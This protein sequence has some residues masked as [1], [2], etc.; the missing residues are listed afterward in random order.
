M[1]NNDPIFTKIAS[2]LLSEYINICY[3]NAE[4]NEYQWYLNQSGSLTLQLQPR[5]NDFFKDLSDLTEKI[6]YEEDRQIFTKDLQK[7]SLLEHMQ[8]GTIRSIEYRLMIEGKPV[9]HALR[10]I[11]GIDSEDK[12]FILAVKNVDEEVRQRL[13]AQQRDRE[14]KIYNQ[15]AESLAKHYD[16]LYYVDMQDNEYFEYSSTDIYKS[17]QVPTS[18]S[19]FFKESEKNL[20]RFVHPEDRQRIV[21]F[22]E[23]ENMLECM[24]N[25]KSYTTEYRLLIGEDVMYCRTSMIWASDKRHILVGIVNINEEIKAQREL[26]ESKRQRTTYS[27][28]VDSL[29]S[30][31]DTIYYVN[32]NSGTVAKLCSCN[33]TDDP[34]AELEGLDFFKDS[35]KRVE[36]MVHENDRDRIKGLLD[37]DYIISTLENSKQYKADYRIVVDGRIEYRRI[38]VMW[39]DEKIHFIVGLENISEEVKREKEQIEALNRA[40]DLA[41]R[42]GLTGTRNMTAYREFEESIQK[43]L[44]SNMRHSPFAILIFDINDLKTVNDTEG[45]KAGDEYIRSACRMICGVFAHSPVF[46]IGG[47]EFAAVLAGS[48]YDNRETLIE[49]LKKRSLDNLRSGQGPVVAVGMGV[50]NKAVDRKVSEVFNRADNDMY[51][52]KTIL[53]SG[54]T[55]K[56]DDVSQGVVIPAD[57][58]RLLDG[59]FEA[60]SIVA[61]GNYVFLCDMKYDY[62]RWSKTA[63]DSF[64]L[65]SE[66]MYGAGDIWEE[67]IHDEDRDTYHEGIAGIFAGKSAGHDMQYRARKINGEYSVCTCKGIVLNDKNGEPEYFGGAIRDHGVHSNVDSLTGLR[68]QYGFFED[69]QSNIIKNKGFRICIVGIAKFSEINEIYG[70]NFGNLVLQ[71]FGRILFYHVGNRGS[72]YRL[73]GTK[74]AVMST[75]QELDFMISR[76]NDLRGVYRDGISIDRR[77]IMLELNAGLIDVNSFNIDSQTVMTCLMFAY[78]ESKTRRHGD[79]VEFNRDHTSGNKQKIEKFHAI[80]AS[81][82]SGYTGFYLLYQPVVDAKTEKLIGAEA[83]L[84]WRSDE[85]GIVPPDEFIPLLEQDPLFPD[86]GEWILTTAI[87]TAKKMLE[88]DPDFVI[89]VN[90]SYTQLEKPDFVDMVINILESTGYPAHHLCLEITERCRLLDVDLLRNIVVSL[91]GRGVQIALDDF[92]TGFS[93]IGIVKDLPFDTIK[94][95][96]SFVRMIEEDE[97]ERELIKSFVSVATT[98]GAAVCIEGIE[99]SAMGEILRQLDVRS[100]QGYY[101]AK[102]LEYDEFIN[103]RK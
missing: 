4:T 43:S 96:R 98:F 77:H 79:A 35:I 82:T 47:D 51:E 97:K 90:L 67:H 88:T 72:V 39:A 76:Y 25:S 99:T 83:L 89:N 58:K 48:D 81:I 38:T 63:V 87:R 14:L 101:Y 73:D 50:Y 74:F 19:D 31:Y 95:D 21:S 86:L 44:D 16:T 26:E 7:E 13:A 78:T 59:L 102:P 15:I 100:F 56:K 28:I 57:R 52:D 9:Y 80:R 62:S 46:R 30:R 12:C 37:K 75:T 70:Y 103:W 32:I 3:I 27:Q 42:D 55:L 91:R 17:M 22:F 84:R 11:R 60:F 94:I 18:G 24:K 68:N 1:L 20:N 10:L 71:K 93:S 85:Y 66:Y 8:K 41:R 54:M 45:H 65:P 61:E 23:K 40:N 5:G 2:A 36:Q 92:G 34:T 29:A 69:I 64:G 49:L 33:K 6:V 53:K